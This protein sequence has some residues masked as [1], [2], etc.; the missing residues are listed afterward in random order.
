MGKSYWELGGGKRGVEG[1]K[2]SSGRKK[3]SRE[4]GVC[5]HKHRERWRVGIAHLDRSAFPKKMVLGAWGALIAI[6]TF[7]ITVEKGLD[8][9]VR[10]P[11]TGI[12]GA[13]WKKHGVIISG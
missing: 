5:V 6:K 3:E 10:A 8:T 9:A 7:H 12:H 1:E 13:E 11:P 4:W 2:G